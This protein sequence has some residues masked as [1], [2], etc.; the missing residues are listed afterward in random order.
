MT[1]ITNFGLKNSYWCMLKPSVQNHGD[2]YYFFKLHTK[3]ESKTSQKLARVL[4]RK[5]YL[6][7]S[8]QVEKEGVERVKCW[9]TKK[10][11]WKRKTESWNFKFEP[12]TTFSTSFPNDAITL[13][14]FVSI[15]LPFW[16]I[17]KET[18]KGKN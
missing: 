13:R 9:L 11:K 17:C 12:A 3:R 5:H 8:A 16:C 15:L 4:E 14:I 6:L 1:N 10:I 2:I 18:K 7:M